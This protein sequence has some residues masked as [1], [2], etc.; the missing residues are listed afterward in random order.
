MASAACGG[1]KPIFPPNQ[2]SGQKSSPTIAVPLNSV[3]KR[4]E[5]GPFSVSGCDEEWPLLLFCGALAARAGAR[6]GHHPRQ[7]PGTGRCWIP[8]P[9]AA[10]LACGHM[11]LEGEGRCWSVASSRISPA[12]IMLLLRPRS[13]FQR[14]SA[15]GRKCIMS[16]KCEDT[17]SASGAALRLLIAEGMGGYTAKKGL[18]AS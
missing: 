3:F 7:E 18:M 16:V 2:G 5:P 8:V 9:A 15:S 6:G 14:A 13:G 4:R 12:Q 10:L 17:V 1:R 11:L